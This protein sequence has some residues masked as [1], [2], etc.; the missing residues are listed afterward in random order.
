MQAK[1]YSGYSANEIVVMDDLLENQDNVTINLVSR[2]VCY[3]NLNQL[4]PPPPCKANP[5]Q[6]SAE[7]G[8]ANQDVNIYSGTISYRISFIDIT[9]VNNTVSTS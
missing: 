7:I 4:C 3:I 1:K 8:A 2:Q 6:Y 5:L 9:F